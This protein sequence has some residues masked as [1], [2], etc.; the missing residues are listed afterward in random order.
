MKSMTKAMVIAATF[1]LA[2]A[3][4]AAPVAAARSSIED[5]DLV[6]GDIAFVYET[7]NVS[8][9]NSTVMVGTD[10]LALWTMPVT[11]LCHYSDFS[12]GSVDNTLYTANPNSTELSASDVNG[13]YG[14][15]Y[16]WNATGLIGLNGSTAVDSSDY[17]WID[18][19]M[20]ELTLDVVLNNSR[21]DSVDGGSVTKDNVIDF[22]ITNNLAAAF[23]TS[24]SLYPNVTI[25]V[26]TPVSGVVT[27]FGG[28]TVVDLSKIALSTSKVYSD[29][30]IELGNESAGAYSAVA[31]WP[32]SLTQ[33]YK[34]AANSN[35]VNFNILSKAVTVTA[36]KDTVVRGN[37][38]SL[39]ITGESVATYFL[40][41]KDA[42][43][44]GT[45]TYPMLV[46]DQPGVNQSAG[47]RVDVM[48]AFT[49]ECQTLGTMANV[50]TNAGGTRTIQYNTTSTTKDRE[51]EFKVARTTDTSQKWDSV[52]VKVEKGAV[53]ITYEGT[54]TYYLGEEIKLTG[55]NTDTNNI[56]LFMTGPNL[57]AN[58]VN[59]T[60][61][62]TVV[63]TGTAA[64]FTSKGVET[65]D[66]WTY[67][68][69]TSSMDNRVDAGT[70]TIYAVAATR[71]KADLS[72]YKYATAALVLK[73]PFVTASVSNPTLAKGDKQYVEG[74]AEGQPTSVWIWI[75]GKNY[76]SL[77]NS[78]S[79]LSDGSFKYDGLSRAVTTDLAAGQYFLVVQHPMMNG[80][81]DAIGQT[82]AGE[83][84][85]YNNTATTGPFNN[86]TV[87]GLQASDAA[88]AL[89]D[90]LN[91]P[92]IDDTYRKVSFMIEEPWIAINA[93]GDQYI[94]EAFDITGTTNLA[95]DDELLVTVTSSSFEPTVKTQ[96][97][98]FSGASGSVKVVAG[99]GDSQSWSFSVG[100]DKLTLADNY[101]VTVECVEVS[102]ATATTTFNVLEP[103][104]T[105]VPP[106]EVPPTEVPPT[107][108]PPTEVPPTQTP[109]FGALVALIGLGAVAALVLRRD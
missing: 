103:G 74:T 79:V 58:G 70:Y 28:P 53:T 47:A 93:I 104:A 21:L 90:I 69:D 72:G 9:L 59:L 33:F 48:A 29:P 2:L 45:E 38:F 52:K 91:S 25:E 109:G 101:I 73:K 87:S 62:S 3:L 55:T 94:G 98:A 78:E 83:S 57:A 50:T 34:K 107:E 102:A 10:T 84:V 106:T 26:T 41:I 99:D 32:S 15:Y 100:A 44:T 77:Y 49:D 60:E 13:I 11:K 39:T 1:V 88:T 64:T 81:A 86:V 67:K 7:I 24:S 75:F 65:D 46:A 89:I 22:K 105:V 71:K 16:A 27:S 92:N 54:G 31:K 17:R 80:I 85:I 20:P 30:R 63:T 23:G 40:Y 43:L 18:I 95:E 19:K 12:A 4:V 96:D 8:A 66:T 68:W 61:A 82:T 36:D 108:V 5:V 56:Y 6:S 14:T 37:P 76:R 97:T 51:F 42:S 35:A